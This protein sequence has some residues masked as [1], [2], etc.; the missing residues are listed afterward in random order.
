M[1][2][3][4]SE[5]FW[6]PC[7]GFANSSVMHDA[8]RHLVFVKMLAALIGNG[9]KLWHSCWSADA[10]QHGPL[11]SKV[12][13]G[14]GIGP[15]GP[16]AP[17]CSIFI[18][19][20]ALRHIIH[21]LP[22][23]TVWKYQGQGSRIPLGVS[24]GVSALRA[25]ACHCLQCWECPPYDGVASQGKCWIPLHFFPLAHHVLHPFDLPQDPPPPF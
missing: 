9:G 11:I 18:R 4:S 24:V 14:K 10:F 8:R 3:E 17:R 25:C 22:L 20:T 21:C 19:P 2:S 6:A 7:F 12:Y 13:F 15:S 16:F 1:T 5:S 23:I